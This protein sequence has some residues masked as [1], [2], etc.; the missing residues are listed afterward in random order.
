MAEAVER[1]YWRFDRNRVGL[2]RL[3]AGRDDAVNLLCFPGAGG[4]SASFRDL[5]QHL[6]DAWRVWAVD[7]PGHGWAAGT[8][9]D[10]VEAMC[11]LYETHLPPH[12]WSKVVLLGNSFG[13]CVAFRLAQR[14]ASR[15][16]PPLGLVLIAIRPPHLDAEYYIRFSQLD[17]ESLLKTL[18]E[19]GG[20]PS[21]W[22]G[23]VA[24]FDEFKDALRA[25]FRAYDEFDATAPC[26][27]V[28]V[29]TLLL[30][31]G[32]DR[33]CPPDH[34][35]AWGRYCPNWTLATVEGGHL[36]V[37]SQPAAAAKRLVEFVAAL[38]PGSD[39]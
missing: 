22:I 3:K 35:A 28:A 27:P 38:H 10:R 6:P 9:L 20:I 32:R 39:G 1:S 25:D 34:L 33:L 12:V 8:P 19:M 31:A 4:Q 5:A 7:P 37:Q 30:C 16:A 29:P 15:D 2:R 17:D 18:I 26:D 21:E 14:L 24:L 11:E 36:F 13:G 23:D